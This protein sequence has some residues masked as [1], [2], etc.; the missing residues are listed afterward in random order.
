VIA[1]D[2]STMDGGDS[3]HPDVTALSE[4]AATSGTSNSATTAR[5]PPKSSSEHYE[6]E[7]WL[8]NSEEEGEHISNFSQ[9]VVYT[10][11]VC[12]SSSI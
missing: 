12:C 8:K 3:P 11:G 1:E 10:C 6:V 7:T 9:S 2:Q 5:T 4:S